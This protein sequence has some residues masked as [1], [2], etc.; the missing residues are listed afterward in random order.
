MTEQKIMINFPMRLID[1]THL[2]T[3]IEAAAALPGHHVVVGPAEQP[4]Y[5]A[6]LTCGL[7]WSDGF[8]PTADEII[9][10]RLAR[11]EKR[12]ASGLKTPRELDGWDL[13]WNK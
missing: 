3:Q 13:W 11:E 7:R 9:E 6:C 12:N 5:F 1:Q 4:P 2:K 8:H 10:A